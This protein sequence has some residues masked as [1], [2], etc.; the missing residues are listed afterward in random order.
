MSSLDIHDLRRKVLAARQ[1]T[2]EVGG[3]TFTLRMP[4][5]HQVQVE[6]LRSG[7]SGA[8]HDGLAAAMTV[9][10]RRL[11]ELAVV[12]WAGAMVSHLVPG[13]EPDEPLAFDADA[14][15]L[16]LDVQTDMAAA[17]DAELVRRLAERNKP[18]E[19]AEKN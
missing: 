15:P 8:S 19:E 5:E 13:Y 18:L 4:T 14:V 7:L 11:L 1:F 10:R 17:L 6:S 9:L 3:V 12:D 16:L 2:H